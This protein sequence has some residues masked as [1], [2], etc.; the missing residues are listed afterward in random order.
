MS[1]HLD[2]QKGVDL[3]EMLSANGDGNISEFGSKLFRKFMLDSGY[4]GIIYIEGGDHPD[5]PYSPSHVFFNL[6]NLGD[7]TTWHTPTS[8]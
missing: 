3:R 2:T 8:S 6:Q 4:N 1:N 7:Y 5:Q